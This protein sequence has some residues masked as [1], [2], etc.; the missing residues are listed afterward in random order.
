MEGVGFEA[1]SVDG[2]PVREG[3]DRGLERAA[4]R[5]LTNGG[6]LAGFTLQQ[7]GDEAGV[8]KGLVY[9]YFG[10]RQALLRSALRHG[11]AEIQKTLAAMPYATYDRRMLHFAKAALAHPDAIQL[12][13]LLLVDRD[14]RL[15]TMPIRENTMAGFERDLKEGWLPPD[16][17]VEALLG[18]QNALV[19]GYILFREGFAR[20]MG[21]DQ[22]TLDARFRRMVTAMARRAAAADWTSPPAEPPPAPA[23][24]RAP[25]DTTTPGLLEK[26][27]LELL[28][29]QGILAGVN[30]R[31]V[32][33]R[34]GVHRGLVYH[35]FGSRREL[36]L[37][38]L[39]RRRDLA[40][41]VTGPDGVP[42]DLLF[43]AGLR[44]GQPARLMTLLALDGDESYLPFGPLPER[45]RVTTR[46][47]AGAAVALGHTLY[48]QSFAREMRIGQRAWDRRVF[49]AWARVAP[50]R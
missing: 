33:E 45:V 13:A 50:T 47:M 36:L 10:D 19:Y 17:D 1:A 12:T 29:E 43:A 39:R 30:L 32:A 15:R 21:V 34:A 6:L 2:R 41:R 40:G 20:Q 22:T 49:A 35:Y 11:A 28:D 7:V 46:D 5:L 27:A 48:R 8:T 14:P 4:L 38:A 42:G 9:H 24:D 18:V 25:A 31:S 37:A 23:A 16:T 3:A 44:D 26:A